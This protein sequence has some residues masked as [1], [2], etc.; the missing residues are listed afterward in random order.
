L[1]EYLPVSTSIGLQHI[2]LVFVGGGAGSVL[3]FAIARWATPAEWDGA[4]PPFPY[5]TMIVNILGCVAIGLLAGWCGKREWAT[6]LLIIGL[7]G[8]FTTFSAFGLDAVRLLDAGHTGRAA[9]Y[10][11]G[12]VVCGLAGVWI[13]VRLGVWLEGAGLE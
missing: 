3:R 4:G 7:L 13:A 6:P 12:S 2:A 8:G 10:V 5:G 1:V 11:A 9:A